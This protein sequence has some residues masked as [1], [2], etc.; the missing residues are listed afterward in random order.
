MRGHLLGGRVR[1]STVIIA[2]VFLITLVVYLL[3]RPVPPSV[4]NQRKNNDPT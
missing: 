4:A 2:A 1:L 3:V